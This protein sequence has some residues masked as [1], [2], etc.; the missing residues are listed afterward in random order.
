MELFHAANQWATRPDDERFSSLEEMYRACKRYADSARGATVRWGDL[1]VEARG[2]DLGLVGKAGVPATVTNYAFGQLAARVGA[3]A[4]Y[5]R[6]LPAT[7]AAQ[8]L[9]FGFANRGETGTDASLL[10]HR[11]GSLLLRAA[12]STR[13]QRVWNYEV[14]DRLMGLCDRHGLVPAHRTFD[15]ADRDAEID[16][17]DP[18]LDRALYASDHDMFAFIMSPDRVVVDPVG[19][20]LRR[21][22][23]VQNSEVGDKRFEFLGFFFRDVCANHI[24]WGAERLAEVSFRH[25]GDVDAKMRDAVVEVRRYLDGAAS[26]DEAKFE[27]FKARI[28]GTKEEVLDALFGKRSLG[29]PKK[30]LE[31][32]YDAV[33]PDEDGDPRSVWGMAQGLT[34]VSQESKFAEDRVALDRAAGKLLSIDF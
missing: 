33:V 28:G 13:Y 30:T 7:L 4:G 15:W 17:S 32:G 10:F 14:V 23:I 20:P 1:R 19:Q 9:N 8:N 26:I 11:N 12:V 31:A 5:L 29:I 25:V 34:R 21:G 18:D 27:G 2:D 3:P 6:D 16:G 22:I 24:V